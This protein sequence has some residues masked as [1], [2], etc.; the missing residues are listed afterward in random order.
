[1]HIC[2]Q[3]GTFCCRQKEVPTRQSD[4]MFLAIPPCCTQ[5]LGSKSWAPLEKTTEP[6]T[7]VSGASGSLL[8]R[9][10]SYLHWPRTFAQFPFPLLPWLE[11]AEFKTLSSSQLGSWSSVTPKDA[12]CVFHYSGI[13]S[14]P[15]T[16][17]AVLG[18]WHG[19]QITYLCASLKEFYK[20]HCRT[21][22]LRAQTAWVQIPALPFIV[23]NLGQAD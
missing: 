16:A 23:V 2:G 8:G 15:G 14:S 12:L 11:R 17:G 21:E 19:S 7:E 1:M 10:E 22:W 20:G 5:S 4:C 13:P 18:A 3:T 9:N 6:F